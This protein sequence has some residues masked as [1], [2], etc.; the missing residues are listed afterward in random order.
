M[1]HSFEYEVITDAN[2]V[3]D[4]DYAE[5]HL[6]IWDFGEFRRG[7]P[8]LLCLR[9][10]QVE[11]LP[12]IPPK[13]GENFISL[14]SLFLRRRLVLGSLTRSDDKPSRLSFVNQS[15]H[16]AKYPAIISPSSSRYVDVN[17]VRDPA[18]NIKELRVWFPVVQSLD[19]YKRG[20]FDQA[21]RLYS[22]ALELIEIRPDVAYLNLVSAIETLAQEVD[23]GEATIDDLREGWED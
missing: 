1:V 6:R 5:F 7:Q 19:E 9:I 10:K 8:R 15:G 20:K 22:E 2:I 14:S 16:T 17:I 23:I 13:K 12:P 3:G 4:F 21:A 11:D 18:T